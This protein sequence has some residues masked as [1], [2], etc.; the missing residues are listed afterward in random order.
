MQQELIQLADKAGALL[1]K[2]KFTIAM[3]ESVTSGILQ[4]AFS[5]AE[6]AT[7]FYQGGITAYNIGQKCRHLLVEPVHAI[8]CNCVSQKVS[9]E[10]STGVAKMFTSDIGVGITGYASPVPEQEIHKLFAFISISKKGKIIVAKKINAPKQ[11]MQQ[12]QVYFA[13]RL[14]RELIAGLS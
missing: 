8:A 4:T 13:E 9:D 12:V 7:L 3:A 6:N 14:M 5:L 10:M 1:T 2:K 11:S